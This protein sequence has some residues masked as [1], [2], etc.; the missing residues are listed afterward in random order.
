MASIDPKKHAP[1]LLPSGK[2]WELVWN[3]EFDGN[4]LDRS[5]WGFRL[6]LMQQR[7]ETL[8]EEGVSFA[9]SC[10]YLNLVKKDGQFYSPHLQTGQNFLD[11]PGGSMCFDENAVKPKF[12]WPIAK[13]EEPKFLHKYGYYECRCKLQTQPGWWSA[14]W[15]QSPI[16]GC[17]PDPVFSGVEVD[18]MENF[19]R[20]GIISHNNHWSGYGDDHLCVGSGDRKLE[21]TADG[22]HVFGLD[23]SRDGYVYYVDGKESW[24]VDGPVSDREQFI[25]IST[26]C[27]GYRSGNEPR[28]DLK[29]AVLPDAFIVDYVRVYDEV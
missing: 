8:T 27:Q 12:A 7:H 20:D 2:K 17:T 26:E 24:R 13:F 11:R 14:F 29:E 4:T 5:K 10:I 1:S 15:L 9:D 6:H 23:W 19:S 16:I 22:F 28:A 3:D 18:I 25:L 21:D